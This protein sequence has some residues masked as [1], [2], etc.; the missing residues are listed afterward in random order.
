LKAWL[1]KKWPI[2]ERFDKWQQKNDW[3][4]FACRT[5]AIIA[6]FLCAKQFGAMLIDEAV[7]KAGLVNPARFTCVSIKVEMIVVQ[8]N[9]GVQVSCL[10]SRLALAETTVAT[11]RNFAANRKVKSNGGHSRKMNTPRQCRL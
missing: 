11:V 7:G 6:G 4:L 3:R 9:D 8:L 10:I 5:I 2:N 1:Q